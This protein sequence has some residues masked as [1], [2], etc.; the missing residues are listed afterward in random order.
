[1]SSVEDVTAKYPSL[2]RFFITHPRFAWVVAAKLAMVK[3][4]LLNF[5]NPIN[6]TRF[7]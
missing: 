7:S 2:S 1:M 5:D 4:M 6:S 3:F